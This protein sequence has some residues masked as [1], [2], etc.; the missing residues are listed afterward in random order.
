MDR[1]NWEKWKRP[2]MP[3][4][5]N[6]LQNNIEANIRNILSNF[7]GYGLVKGGNIGV[8]GNN[9]V[10]DQFFGCNKNGEI[11]YSATQQIVDVSAYLSSGKYVSVVAQFN[12]VNEGEEIDIDNNS[13]HYFER[14][15]NIIV[16]K[17]SMTEFP[18]ITDNEIL[19]R[20]VSFNSNGSIDI[21]PGRVKYLNKIE[22]TLSK[23]ETIIRDIETLNQAKNYADNLAAGAMSIA[24]LK[25]I[26][27]ENLV[28]NG[29]F[30][31]GLQYW[32]T[33]NNAELEVTNQD[34]ENI[35]GDF[36]NATRAS[37]LQQTVVSQIVA[38]DPPVN[39]K[40]TARASIKMEVGQN[41]GGRIRLIA[42]DN[43]DNSLLQEQSELITVSDLTAVEV[44]LTIPVN[45]KRVKLCLE[46]GINANSVYFG[47]ISANYGVVATQYSKSIEEVIYESESK[48]LK[49]NNNLSDLNSFEQARNNINV[50]SKEES[51]SKVATTKLFHGFTL[52]N[53]VINYN[54]DIDIDIGKCADDSLTYII[55]LSNALTK[56]VNTSWAEGN[57]AGGLANGSTWGANK[58]YHI[59]V[60]LKN[61]LITV[62]A[63]FTETLSFILPANYIAK[64]RLGACIT[65][66]SGNIYQGTWSVQNR[67]FIFD[68]PILISTA[69]PSANTNLTIPIPKNIFC[70]ISGL[71][72]LI[73]STISAGEVN[74]WLR[75]INKNTDLI[76]FRD[77]RDVYANVSNCYYFSEILSNLNSQISYRY[78]ILGTYNA[79]VTELY[80][81]SYEEI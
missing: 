49:K 22:D 59:F 60:I 71:Y 53:N 25:Q 54:T 79:L 45:T 35:F 27:F 24:G 37:T 47:E 62:D 77:I 9:L 41:G 74:L 46:I 14:E 69:R 32:T 20:D 1:I 58:T 68:S 65:D 5:F 3:A 61:D 64:R 21:I 43:N 80:I 36:L 78:I 7:A 33:E 50:L 56:K 52:S 16:L 63:I 70:K 30:S 73:T 4:D 75:N 8:A 15:S 23:D 40:L 6:N 2:V 81:H 72:R 12:R 10:I 31:K 13:H 55:E 19:L 18:E 42:L 57:N 66:N 38:T 44:T 51:I 11:I 34:A 26:S 17:E 48:Y 67:K 29:D 28:K 76:C 39:N